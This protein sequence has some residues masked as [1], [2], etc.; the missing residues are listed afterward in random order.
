MNGNSSRLKRAKN[1]YVSL[2]LTNFILNDVLYLILYRA[3]RLLLGFRFF[4]HE[5]LVLVF[6]KADVGLLIAGVE[7]TQDHESL[8]LGFFR[9]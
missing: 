4:L 3:F 2:T 8:V 6:R 1:A 5:S 7:R 9:V